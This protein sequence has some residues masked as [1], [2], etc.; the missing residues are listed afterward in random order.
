MKRLSGFVTF[1]VLIISALPVQAA[2]SNSFRSNTPSRQRATALNGSAEH[3]VHWID[4]TQTDAIHASFATTPTIVTE[5][6]VLYG[7]AVNEDGK[8]FIVEPNVFWIGTGGN[9]SYP[10]IRFDNVAIPRKA[11]INSAKLEGS[12]TKDSWI[13]LNYALNAENSDNSRP[14]TSESRPSKRRL[15]AKPFA[16]S[17]DLTWTAGNYYDLGAV[18]NFVQSIV[19]RPGWK[20]GNALSIIARGNLL[21]SRKFLVNSGTLAPRLTINYTTTR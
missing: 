7:S 21:W 1:L 16:F 14:F 6:L 9:T 15:F 12:P 2:A 3:G 4:H 5:T 19:N 8:E 18:S 13:S 17:D 11:K 20:S 10:G